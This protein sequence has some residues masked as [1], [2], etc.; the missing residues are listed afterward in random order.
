MCGTQ[1][2]IQ[3]VTLQSVSYLSSRKISFVIQFSKELTKLEKN[4]KK[5]A[6]KIFSQ[7]FHFTSGLLRKKTFYLGKIRFIGKELFSK[8]FTLL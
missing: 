4:R 3:S 5:L 6:M 2:P 8:I 7:V 1:E